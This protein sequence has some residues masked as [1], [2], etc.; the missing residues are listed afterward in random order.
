MLSFFRAEKESELK[1]IT[2]EV[3]VRFV[4]SLRKFWYL[5]EFW[6]P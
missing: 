5:M 3:E 4:F 1:R 6:N 2:K